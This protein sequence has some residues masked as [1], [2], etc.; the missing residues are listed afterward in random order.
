M[1]TVKNLYQCM[2]TKNDCYTRNTSEKKLATNQQDS[3]YRNYYKGPTKIV[4]HS[5][6]SNNPWLCRYVQPDDGILGKN[7]NDNSWN[8]SGLSTCVNAFIGKAD[9]GTVVIYQTL[10][11]DYRPWGVGSGSKGSYNDCA[12]Q[13]EICEDGL[14]DED[15]ANECFESAAQLCA[16][17]CDTFDIPIDGIVS[18]KEAHEQGYGSNHGDP[19]HWWSKIGLSMSGFRV[20]VQEILDADK[21]D[22]NM[23]TE[24]QTIRYN[25]LDEI[26][27][28]AKD[29]ISKLVKK[30]YLK[31][32]SYGLDLSLDMIR[33]LVILNRAGMFGE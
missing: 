22:Q 2:L 1:I 29:T 3:R 16:Y 21:E 25:T 10:P 24:K 8:R 9:D 23:D 14:V 4:V 17:L 32:Q 30:N 7:K 15:Y 11:W 5:T 12:I 6:G 19:D 26:P 20:R 31:G 18:H 33:I 13:F 27:D 28:Y